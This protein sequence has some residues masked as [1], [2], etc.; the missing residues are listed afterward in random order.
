MGCSFEAL[1]KYHGHG[2]VSS[3]GAARPSVGLDLGV[4]AGLNLVK[5]LELP[6]RLKSTGADAQITLQ[7]AEGSD[8]HMFLH[9]SDVPWSMPI[10]PLLATKGQAC[11]ENI[12]LINIPEDASDV[13]LTIENNLDSIQ[14]VHV[15]G[16]RFQVVSM[17][18]EGSEEVHSD[19]HLLRDTI[20]I[21]AGGSV[22]LRG[23]ADNAGMWMLHAMS[24]NAFHRG[25]ATVLN[26]L[27][28][29]QSGVPD[30]MPSYPCP[31]MKDVHV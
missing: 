22:T 25:A 21:P 12:P 4:S 31:E 29:S 26:I 19:G 11:A 7:L 18:E 14:A 27:P 1:L 20:P 9:T 24:A 15:H 28:S 6:P 16:M 10:S 2:A 23:A 30:H 13:E 5:P 3:S 8:G 17:L